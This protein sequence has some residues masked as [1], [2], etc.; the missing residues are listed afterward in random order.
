MLTGTNTHTQGV[1]RRLS[2]ASVYLTSSEIWRVFYC[3]FRACV[4]LAY[5]GRWDQGIDPTTQAVPTQEEFVPL[6]EGQAVSTVNGLIDFDIN[7][8]NVMVGEDRSTLAAG[9]HP[10]D[11]SPIFKIGDLGDVHA[12]RTPEYRASLKTHAMARVSGNPTV[13]CILP[14]DHQPLC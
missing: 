11:Q 9:E 8:R 6:S 1:A 12:F 14:L 10:H 4:A 5:P 13:C 7:D 2:H 3:L